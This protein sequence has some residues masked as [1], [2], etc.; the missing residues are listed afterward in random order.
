MF[1]V[2]FLFGVNDVDEFPIINWNTGHRAEGDYTESWGRER[3]GIGGLGLTAVMDVRLFNGNK[4]YCDTLL[5]EVCEPTGVGLFMSVDPNVPGPLPHS[6]NYENA[7]YLLGWFHRWNNP[8]PHTWQATKTW[9]GYDGDLTFHD[10]LDTFAFALTKH[11]NPLTG[12]EIKDHNIYGYIV[13]H[14]DPERSCSECNKAID[15]LFKWIR[16]L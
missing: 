10:R 8:E 2:L 13:C 4:A 9:P 14:E 12:K 7:N 1:L 11:V 16:E 3:D 5:K 6:T 15:S